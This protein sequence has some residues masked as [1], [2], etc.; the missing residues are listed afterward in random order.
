MR[1][2]KRIQKLFSSTVLAGFLAAAPVY[3]PAHADTLKPQSEWSLAKIDKSAQGGTSYCT[4]SR[5]YDGNIVLSLGRNVTEEYSLAIDFQEPVFER[6]KSLKINLQP[7]PGQIRAYDMVP[8]SE[9]ALVIRLGWDKGFFDTLVSSQQMKVKIGDKNYD[10]SMP[11]ID[12]GQTELTTCMEE[13]KTAS[14]GGGAAKVADAPDDLLN[15]QAGS[16]SGAFGASKAGGAQF[17]AVSPAAPVA[18][19]AIA[20]Q[21]KTV[22][23]GEKGILKSFADSIRAQEPS[24]KKQ[25]EAAVA[26]P[27]RNFAKVE[28][29]ADIRAD[30]SS[31]TPAPLPPVADEPV[32]QAAR[33]VD[34]APPVPLPVMVAAAPVKDDSAPKLRAAEAEIAAQ[35][36]RI[37]ALEAEKNSL[38]QKAKDLDGKNKTM[39]SPADV[40]KLETRINELQIQNKQLDDTVRQSQT[41]IA[42]TAINTE[43]KSMKRI[44]ELESKLEAATRDNNVLAKQLDSQKLQQEDGRL[45]LVA[46]D[47]NLEQATR[48]YNE[49]EREI[50]RL[51]L[52]LEQERTGCNR[53]KAQ[54][55]QMLFDPAV[56]DQKQIE[57][58]AELED[59]LKK[60]KDQFGGAAPVAAESTTAGDAALTA[61]ARQLEGEKAAL[62]TK[63]ASLEK[64]LSD[65]PPLDNSITP[66]P[67][68][69]AIAANMPV[70]DKKMMELEAAVSLAAQESQVLRDSNAALVKET[71]KLRAQ[72]SGARPKEGGNIYESIAPSSGDAPAAAKATNASYD[73]PAMQRLL[74]TSGLAV[75]GMRKNTS[76]L[77]GADNFAWLENGKVKGLAS[78]KKAG[79]A[80]FDRMIDDYIVYQKKQCA[81][82]FAS[83][84]SPAADDAPR[85]MALYEIACVGTAGNVSSSL[86]FFEDKGRFVAIANEIAAADMNVAMDSRDRIANTVRGL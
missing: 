23:E 33:A 77:P 15:A 35:K 13:L 81:G 75:T 82:D 11:K 51:G 45:S 34:V 44:M 68:A 32:V 10:F 58:L 31:K 43:T 21:K 22:E 37:A 85:K 9:R 18:D 46:G 71:E 48:R 54:I 47:W 41:R 12:R 16:M 60:A 65:R 2:K 52:Q 8:S 56:A 67:G 50:R 14:K 64:A 39:A 80:S 29:K 59:E 84:P 19:T 17:A 78:V 74:Q 61:R 42:E 73:L 86:V 76:G 63:V 6:D 55:E 66:M 83:M 79:S 1:S 3:A 70:D 20:A 28:E 40:A 25:E 27:S 36:V 53:E 57:K 69:A 26:A 7:G 24:L 5:K 72:L 30:I 49:A 38:Q 62:V 4:L